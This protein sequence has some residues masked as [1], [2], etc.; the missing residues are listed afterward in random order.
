MSQENKMG[1]MSV[2]KLLLSMALPIMASM[3]VQ[4]LYNIVDSIFV[5]QVSQD[6]LS[7]VSI[8]FPVQNLMISIA[9]GTGVGINAYLSRSLGEKN[10]KNVHKAATNGLFLA[11]L[12]T[13]VFIIF[14]L[15][16]VDMYVESQ[17]ST[18]IISEYSKE[19]ITICSVLSFGI[20]GQITLERLLQGTGKTI[21]TMFTQGIGAIINIILDPILIFGL[22]GF[23]ELGVSGAALATVIGQI[24]AMFLALF[25]NLKKNHEINFSFKGFKPHLKTIKTIYSV[26]VPSILMMS[27]ASIMVYGMN[28]ILGDFSDTAVAVFGVY[29][30]LQSFIFMPVFGLNNGMVPILAYNYGAA[31]KDRII[32]TIKFAIGCSVCI[33]VVGFAVFQLFPKELLDMFDASTD[34][35]AIGTIALKVISLSFIPAA[36]NVILLS[37]FQAFGRGFLSLVVSVFRQLIIL[38]PAAYVFSLFCEGTD[39]SLIWFSFPI[40][41]IAS[42]LFCAV[43]TIKVYREVIKPIGKT[44]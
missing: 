22:L 14:G 10:E 43:F 40:A 2:K 39:V 38:L 6:A 25:F 42:A 19:Y 44:A 12:S 30:K 34:M 3:L 15:F 36:F 17:T 41:E 1:V 7:A 29:F 26:G 31:K 21:Y 18:P 16:F 5:A 8:A 11:M 20:F 37:C 4:A 9:S 13:L 35:E 27:I 33:M 24:C 23:P 32:Q 28:K